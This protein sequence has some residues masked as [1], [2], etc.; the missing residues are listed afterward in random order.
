MARS[1]LQTVVPIRRRSR[2]PS[3]PAAS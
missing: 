3:Q 1:M 2:N